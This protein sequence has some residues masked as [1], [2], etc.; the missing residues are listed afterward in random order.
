MAMPLMRD[1]IEAVE[2]HDKGDVERTLLLMWPENRIPVDEF[3]AMLTPADISMLKYNVGCGRTFYSIREIADLIWK[4]SNYE[5][6][7]EFI[8]N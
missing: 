5:R 8:T 2:I 7:D 3:H 1:D 6:A 4:C